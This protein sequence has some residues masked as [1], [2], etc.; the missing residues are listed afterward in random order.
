MAEAGEAQEPKPPR[1][2]PK[3]ARLRHISNAVLR[4]GF[5]TVDDLAAELDVSRMTIHRD[6]DE[7]QRTSTLRKVR[8]GASAHRSTQFESDFQFRVSAKRPEKLAMARVAATLASEGDVVVVDDSSTAGEVVPFLL[9]LTPLTIIT[10]FVPVME[11]LF[12]IP[13]VKL[14]GLAGEYDPRYHS[15]LGIL[16]ESALAEVYAD[17]LFTSSSAVQGDNIFHQDQRIVT[18]KQAMMRASRRRVLMMDH[19][20][21]GH[22]ALH[23]V[24]DL[25]EFTHLIVDD[26]LDEGSLH[27]LQDTGVDVLVARVDDQGGPG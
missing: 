4:D 8:G 2:L 23:R 14:I 27:R 20:K 11:K 16:C 18:A 1:S 7:L 3:A 9:E 13:D 17:V 10:N 5:V 6:L 19:S 26:G 21:F 25:H 24:A 22:G 15:F 12:A